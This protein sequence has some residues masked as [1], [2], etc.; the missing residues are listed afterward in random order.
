MTTVTKAGLLA[1]YALALFAFF[2]G[3]GSGRA[4]AFRHTI[5]TPWP[6]F[7]VEKRVD[8]FEWA[9]VL[10]S[11]AWGVAAVGWLAFY[12]YWRIRGVETDQ[13]VG[14]ADSPKVHAVI[15]LIAA[16]IW[17]TVSVAPLLFW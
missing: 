3:R 14:A 11:W 4:E 1:V 8:G 2:G 15:W 12:A 6:W 7:V 10:S 17:I 16:M 9:I 5:G 13:P